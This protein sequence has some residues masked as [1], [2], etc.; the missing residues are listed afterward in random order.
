MSNNTAESIRKQ[1]R[2]RRAFAA[3]ALTLI[4]VG[5]VVAGPMSATSNAATQTAAA[6]PTAAKP[7]PLP[8]PYSAMGVTW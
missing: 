5:G 3:A 8:Q 2:I 7:A 1:R 6:K 4:G